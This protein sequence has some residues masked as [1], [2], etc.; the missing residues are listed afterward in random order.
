[1]SVSIDKLLFYTILLYITG[2]AFFYLLAVVVCLNSGL[3]DELKEGW[4]DGWMDGW[5]DDLLVVYLVY[6]LF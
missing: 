5:M 4:I 1:M 2:Y 6:E 3:I